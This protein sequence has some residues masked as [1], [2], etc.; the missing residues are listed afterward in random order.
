MSQ[1]SDGKVERTPRA[2]L[3]LGYVLCVESIHPPS[4]VPY[5]PFYRPRGEQGL[6]MGERGK[7]QEYRRSFEGF[8]SSFFPTPASTTWQIVSEVACL[9]IFVGHALASFSKWVRPIP[10]LRAA[11]RTGLLNPDPIGSGCHGDCSF[12][13]CRGWESLLRA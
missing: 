3:L 13:H 4:G 1:V 12:C 9:L 2:W 8:G 5:P 11:C 6:Q 10:P 7:Y